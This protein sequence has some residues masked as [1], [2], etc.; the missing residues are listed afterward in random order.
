MTEIE[1]ETPSSSSNIIVRTAGGGMEITLDPMKRP[2]KRIDVYEEE[3]EE[4]VEAV[5][6]VAEEAEASNG[7]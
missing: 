4:F 1:I 3:V 6:T 7:G 5:Q 2:V